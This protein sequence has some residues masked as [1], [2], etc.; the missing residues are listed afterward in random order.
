MSYFNEST[1]LVTGAT[2]LIGSN[3]VH[4]LMEIGG[5]KVI[6]NGRSQDK[7]QTIF[8]DY[9]D[10]PLFSTYAHDVSSPFELPNYN[11]DYI[12]HAASPLENKIIKNE[13]LNVINPNIFGTI[14]CLNFLLNQYQNIGLKG[15]LIL[16]SSVTVYANY[17]NENLI[18]KETDT[19]VT[20]KIENI[21]AS[22]SQSKRMSEVIANAYKKQYNS[23]IVSARLSTVYGDSKFKPETAFFEFIKNAISGED[24]SVNNPLVA[25][26]DNIY[27]DDVI[28]ALLVLAEK[29]DS[30]DVYNVSSNNELGNFASVYDIA[31]AIVDITNQ[32]RKSKNLNDI[33]LISPSRDLTKI[34]PG[35]ILDNSKLKTLGWNLKTSLSDGLYKTIMKN[36]ENI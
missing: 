30:G 22:Y 5:I 29:G 11:I 26:R 19:N 2:G 18:V 4:K 25:K 6:A 34:T 13:P 14:N 33:K 1:I 31:K 12:F 28:N 16:F 23:D 35:L 27:V 21:S 3:L 32:F 36:I 15:R 17:S 10:S 24:I 8:E 7:L 9:I 20:D